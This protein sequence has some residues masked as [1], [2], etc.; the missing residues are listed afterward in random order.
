MPNRKFIVNRSSLIGKFLLPVTG[1]LLLGTILSGCN[2]IGTSKPAALQV[3]SV[4]E[5]SV[6]LDGVHLGKTPFYSD[7]LK[8]GTHTIKI[9]ASEASFV[10]KI[11]LASET[12]TVVNRE[13]NDNFMAQSGEI[14]W[15][16]KGK[17]SIF[18]SSKPE[19]AEVEVGGKFKGETPILIDD[20]DPGEHKVSVSRVGYATRQ[21]TIKTSQKYQ[22]LADVTLASQIAKD[23]KNSIENVETIKKLEILRTPQGYL[24]VR[25]EPSL[26]SAEVG[27]VN[28]GDQLEIIQETED[29]VKINF[30]GKLGWISVQYTKKL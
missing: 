11:D 12:L 27:R 3:S 4:P 14:L 5:A 30:E 23:S 21:F 2:L 18:I 20:L 26:T 13:L 19:A 10:Q 24:R 17:D 6:F 9:A 22:I 16:E 7:Q 25:Q 8:S 29:W 1:Y 28:T 15:L